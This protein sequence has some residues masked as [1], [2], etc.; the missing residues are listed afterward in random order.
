MIS[1][2][3]IPVGK[4]ARLSLF[5]SI[6]LA[7]GLFLASNAVRADLNEIMLGLGAEMMTFPGQ[8]QGEAR[9]IHLNGAPVFLRTTT[10]DNPLEQ[11]L[12]HYE[13]LCEKRQGGLALDFGGP[14]TVGL[15]APTST[16]RARRSETGYVACL[17]LGPNSVDAT[18]LANRLHSFTQTGALGH[19]GNLRYAYAK[20]VSEATGA[21]TLILTMW[22]ETSI[23][24]YEMIPFDGRDA[25]GKDLEGI[26]RPPKSQRILSSWE[27]GEPYGLTVYSTAETKEQVDRFYRAELPKNGW[28]PIGTTRTHWPQL[29]QARTIFVER[30]DHVAVILLQSNDRGGSIATLLTSDSP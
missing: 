1:L 15:V 9:T 8:T 7:G 2:A 26:P 12:D 3:R 10:V 24:L 30:G 5:S 23:N 22:T 27:S 14:E 20:R 19:L 11:V 6:A 16:L 18:S 25:G 21:K 28:R 29:E 4:L 17:D 13:A